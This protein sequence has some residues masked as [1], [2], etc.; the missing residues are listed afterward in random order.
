MPDKG[1]LLVAPIHPGHKHGGL[2]S[3]EFPLLL[4]RWSSL[5]I[6]E[7]DQRIPHWNVTGVGAR[8]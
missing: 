5:F 2:E 1:R 4:S 8:F 7:I 6:E 3:P